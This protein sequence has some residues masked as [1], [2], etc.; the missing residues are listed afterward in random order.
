MLTALLAILASAA[1]AG[2]NGA[3][4]AFF[5]QTR[6]EFSPVLDGEKVVHAFSILNKGSRMLNIQ[7]VR[8]G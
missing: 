4:A 5:P 2:D 8:T 1:L 6:Y 7:R 3:P